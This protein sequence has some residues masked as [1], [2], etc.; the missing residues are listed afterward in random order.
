MHYIFI[1][2][3]YRSSI[4]LGTCKTEGPVLVL[5]YRASTFNIQ[6]WVLGNFYSLENAVAR[7]S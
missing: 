5:Q 7:V 3:D 1:D 6:V 4:I 2:C